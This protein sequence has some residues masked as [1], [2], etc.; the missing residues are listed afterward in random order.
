VSTKFGFIDAQKAHFP[1]IK[2]CEWAD[3]STSGYYEWRNRPTSTTAIRREH[4][5]ALVTA[6]F[7]NSDHTYAYRRVHAQ[8]LRQGELAG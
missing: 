3:V 4:F 1:I 7:K 5:T 6:I 2:M 8:L